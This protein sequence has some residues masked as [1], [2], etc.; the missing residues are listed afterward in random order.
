M[1]WLVFLTILILV[2]QHLIAGS[3]R[4][5]GVSFWGNCQWC[6]VHGWCGK[7]LLWQRANAKNVSFKNSLQ[8]PISKINSVDK[9]KSSCYASFWHLHVLMGESI[10]IQLMRIISCDIVGLKGNRKKGNKTF[11]LVVYS[12][13][14][15]KIQYLLLVFQCSPF[16]LDC[17]ILIAYCW[18]SSGD[19]VD[20]LICTICWTHGRSHVTNPNHDLSKK[21]CSIKLKCYSPYWKW[22]CH[23]AS[24]NYFLVT[25]VSNQNEWSKTYLTLISD[26]VHYLKTN[27]PA[28]GYCVIGLTWVDLY[29]DE[30]WNFVL[31]ESSCEEGCAVVSFGH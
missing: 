20:C 27:L 13:W 6:C 3:I 7:H 26:L 5:K 15:V 14:N 22:L 29:P 4:R 8:R 9:T 17:N 31:G 24:N 30:D 1:T 12:L 23:P 19:K 21:D 11:A 10:V 16:I 2:L 25:T 28:D 18:S